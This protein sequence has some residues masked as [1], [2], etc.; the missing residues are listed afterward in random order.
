MA[1]GATVTYFYRE[2][3]SSFTSRPSMIFPL[4]IYTQNRQ[5]ITQTD[6]E[7]YWR[8]ELY[9]LGGSIGYKKYPGKFFGIGNSTSDR[10]E[11]EY[12]YRESRLAVNFQKRVWE[13]LYT[14]MHYELSHNSVAE[15]EAGGMLTGGEIPGSRGGVNSGLGL[16]LNWDTRDN[17]FFPTGGSCHQFTTT[18]YGGGLAGDFAF[19]KYTVDLRHFHLFRARHVL[20]VQGYLNIITGDPPYN[21]MSLIGGENFMRGYYQGRYRDR[22]MMGLQV[23][24]RSPQ[25]KRT[26]VIFF[27]GLADVAE[28]FTDFRFTE[29][30]YSVG[31]GLR[32]M[33]N[34][35]EKVNLRL[36]FG[37]GRESFGV[38]MKILEAF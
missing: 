1:F 17:I 15:F 29:F 28:R 25:W 36:D 9:H 22:H 34:P 35:E 10:D 12:T 11:E 4:L 38:Y 33:I 8:D 6:A 7:Y 13:S 20:A 18:F 16:L 19:N 5:F 2:S 30:K 26:G 23:E 31:L 3:G 32:Y 21:A 27:A 37:F 24:Y 14:G